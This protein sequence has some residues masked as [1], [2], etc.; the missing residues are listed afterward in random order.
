MNGSTSR[1]V[2]SVVAMLVVGTL[3]G[4]AVKSVAT[5]DSIGWPLTSAQTSGQEMAVL[6]AGDETMT[7]A[8]ADTEDE[9]TLGLGYREELPNDGMLFVIDPAAQ[10]SIWMK[11]MR[12][13]LDVAWL[14]DGKVIWVEHNMPVAD[15]AQAEP[16]IY[17]PSE[18][19]DA[20]I[21]VAAGSAEAKGLTKG[22]RVRIV[23]LQ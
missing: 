21:E 17:G 1:I 13:P 6:K 3:A 19:V 15:P 2:G 16:P 11:G 4:C 18:S 5:K 20:I 22:S 8:I 10:T 23:E 14:R 12:F 9:R 7:L